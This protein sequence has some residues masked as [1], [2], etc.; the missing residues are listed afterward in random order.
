MKH[1]LLSLTLMLFAY[2]GL[3]GQRDTLTV[4][5]A[6]NNGTITIRS[7]KSGSLSINP[8]EYNGFGNIQAVY[9]TAGADTMI[10][11]QNVL[12]S[13][14]VAR[15]RKTAFYFSYR[16]LGITAATA[17]WLNATYFNPVNLRQLNVT[18]AVRDSLL[19][20]GSVPVGTIIFNTTL[21]SP[22]I[23]IANTINWR[24]F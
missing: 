9:S 16:Q 21:D 12:T 22:Q 8:F 17:L 18:T 2:I 7:Q 14:V 15:Y 19:L 11:L 5:Q 1:L 13:K 6:T 3:S 4:S 10:Y 23:R 24:S 20:W